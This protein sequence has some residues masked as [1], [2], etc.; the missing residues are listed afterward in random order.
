MFP[1]LFGKTS[2]DFIRNKGY[3]TI[4]YLYVATARRFPKIGD[5]MYPLG[6]KEYHRLFQENISPL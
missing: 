5:V 1:M 2:R 4:Y 6:T 3:C